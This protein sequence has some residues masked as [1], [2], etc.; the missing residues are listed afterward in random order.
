MDPAAFRLRLTEQEETYM[1]LLPKTTRNVL[2]DKKKYEAFPQIVK[3]AEGIEELAKIAFDHREHLW[4]D[5]N[6]EEY[7]TTILRTLD[8]Q[9]KQG[10]EKG[11][12]LDVAQAEIYIKEF[13][14]RAEKAVKSAGG[15][16]DAPS[17]TSKDSLD[18]RVDYLAKLDESIDPTRAWT[19]RKLRELFGWGSA[20][21]PAK[22]AKG[23]DRETADKD[24][25]LAA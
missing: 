4:V 21:V 18:S 2:A 14:R 19:G 24:S 12:F 1:S 22:D 6:F 5:P 15:L 13:T 7:A 16:W 20:V 11:G 10:L 25:S 3:V 23:D 17:F 8:L 9:L